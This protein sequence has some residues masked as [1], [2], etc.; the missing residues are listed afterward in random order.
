M[1][2]VHQWFVGA[3]LSSL[4]LAGCT[5]KV[6][7]RDQ[8]SGFLTNYDDLQ[9]VK[10]ASGH[11]ALRWVSPDFKPSGYDT[12]VFDRLQIFLAIKP[13]ERVNLQTLQ[14]IQSFSS[15]SVKEVL[16]QTYRVVP[17]AQSVPSG[18]KAMVMRTAMTGVAATN[19][20]MRW[21]EVVPI[22]AVVGATEAVTGY[23][24]QNTE[25]YVEVEFIDLATGKPLAKVVRKVFGTPLKNNTQQVSVDDFKAAISE[26]VRDL[27]TFL[28]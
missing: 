3:A 27:K 1:K 12:V 7:E 13:T 16:K 17:T 9:Q 5:S 25:L 21:Y 28:K 23:R 2:I 8:F 19:E 18:A 14:Q 22:A 11:P 26:T 20:G 15:D 24:D 10:S 4:L 6:T